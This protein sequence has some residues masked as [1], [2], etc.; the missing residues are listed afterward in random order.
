[1]A[2]E[3]GIDDAVSLLD[4]HQ[5]TRWTVPE[6]E[7]TAAERARLCVAQREVDAYMAT[8]NPGTISLICEDNTPI[9]HRPQPRPR[10]WMTAQLIASWGMLTMLV[11][12][13]LQPAQHASRP[14]WIGLARTQQKYTVIG[15]RG[16]S[17]VLLFRF[18]VENKRLILPFNGHKK[19]KQY[20]YC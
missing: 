13:A 19:L 1:M 18:S 12:L 4:E 14:A 15:S 9:W 3:S 2:T 20:K 10:W 8:T 5:H 16:P 11:W 17:P 7:P 6:H